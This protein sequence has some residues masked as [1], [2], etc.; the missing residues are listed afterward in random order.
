MKSRVHS[1]GAASSML[2]V[3]HCVVGPSVP[4]LGFPCQTDLARPVTFRRGMHARLLSLC[5][6]V[7]SSFEHNHHIRVGIARSGVVSIYSA[8]SKKRRWL[9]SSSD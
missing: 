7:T 2:V 9:R 5:A 6:G 4:L 1:L 8:G 3:V